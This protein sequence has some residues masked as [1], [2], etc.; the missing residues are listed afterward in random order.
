MRHP[1]GRAGYVRTTKYAGTGPDHRWRTAAPRCTGPLRLP[2][3]TGRRRCLPAPAAARPRGR[4]R[5]RPRAGRLR[6][7]CDAA[8]ARLFAAGAETSWCIGAGT[9]PGPTCRVPATRLASR[10]GAST[11]TCAS[12]PGPDRGARLPL[13]LTVGAWLL[14][15]P[16]PDGRRDV[17]AG[18][19]R[20]RRPSRPRARELG[21]RPARPDRAR[22]WCSGTGRPAGAR[23]RPGYDDPRAE[24]YDEGV[25]AALAERGPRR[26]ARPGPG[27]VGAAEGR[28]PGPWQVLAG[29]AGA[30]GGGWRGELQ[31][32]TPRPTGWPTSWRPG[33][34]RDRPGW[35]WR[36]S[37]RP[38]PASPR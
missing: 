29:A 2:G 36:W 16:A 5:R 7:A 12:V 37:G 30:A 19:R 26:P 6:A 10:R 4:R 25:A 31:L 27:A 3:A 34:G 9:G 15:R 23:R 20:R 35:S 17:P 22:C 18:D 1:T 28:R 21:A 13:S 8:V 14:A 11:W 24:A 32:R 33:S 38:R